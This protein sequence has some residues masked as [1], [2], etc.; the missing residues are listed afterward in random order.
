MKRAL[1]AKPI[2]R[3]VLEE[4]EQLIC[5]APD[6]RPMLLDEIR[7]QDRQR[8]GTQ[9]EVEQLK[10]E[11]QAL[12]RKAG[13]LLD[14]LD[15]EFAEQAKSKIQ[16]AQTRKREIASRLDEIDQGPRMSESEI[17]QMADGIIA[18]MADLL[19]SLA[20]T[21]NS[22]IRHVFETLIDE[23]V[24]DL[25]KREVSFSLAIPASML[26]QRDLCPPVG[27]GSKSFYRTNKWASIPLHAVTIE[28]PAACH[29]ECQ[30]PFEPK[31]CNN[32]RRKR[33][34]A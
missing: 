30:R 7:S 18:D 23:A 6:L 27:S 13:S 11:L 14:Q 34:A 22:D 26:A 25:E 29:A 5:N 3:A 32:C 31:G 24:C 15:G 9:D 19:D 10:K 1:P 8:G 21:Q 33:K 4:I 17:E 20:S 16:K 28:L 2:H 12:D